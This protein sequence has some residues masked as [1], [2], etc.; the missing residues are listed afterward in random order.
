LAERL[1]LNDLAYCA[2]PLQV[3]VSRG[4]IRKKS[5]FRNLRPGLNQTVLF[6]SAPPASVPAAILNYAAVI[7]CIID[8][9]DTSGSQKISLDFPGLQFTRLQPKRF[10]KSGLEF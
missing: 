6:L 2:L 3:F 9:F 7:N 8:R 1:N 10:D 5:L 4:T